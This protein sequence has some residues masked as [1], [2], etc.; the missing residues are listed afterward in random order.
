MDEPQTSPTALAQPQEETTPLQRLWAMKLLRENMFYADPT[1]Y[2]LTDIAEDLPGD[3][4]P[5][6]HILS[7]VLPSAAIISN[8]P[9]K[10]RAQIDAAINKIKSTSKSDH[11][12]HKE[13]LHNA[14][15]M[16][17]GAIIPG[18]ILSLALGKFGLRLPRKG[19]K[20]RAPLEV[21]NIKKL[22]GIGAQSQVRKDKLMSTARKM[23]A[24][25]TL[26]DTLMNSGLAAATGAV[27]PYLANKSQVSDKALDDARKIMEEHPYLTSL[28]ASEVM[29]VLNKHKENQPTAGNQTLANVG[30]GAGVGA[31]TGAAGAMLPTAAT[32]L[33]SLLTL[34]KVGPKGGIT[35]P[36]FLRN[37]TQG[38]KTNALMGG[39][40]GVLSGLA[41][42]NVI[43]DEYQHIK[44][45]VTPAPG[46]VQEEKPVS[47]LA[48]YRN[49]YKKPISY[50]I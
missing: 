46:N 17:K 4:K 44:E 11:D 3:L 45:Q 12:L 39:G 18:A 49:E 19:G 16:G 5:V 42:K 41:S 13:M 29:S 20:W 14:I 15:S 30:I 2:G 9:A 34:G 48:A 24:N 37:A 47:A 23:L 8:D 40:L 22:L 43:N 27:Y 21:G 35:S 38:L 6:G 28:P 31:A 7:N 36:A 1:T 10:R 25:N 50:T 32:A 26:H 33:L